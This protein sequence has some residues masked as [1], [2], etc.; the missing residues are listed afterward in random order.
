[1]KVYLF[2]LHSFPSTKAWYCVTTCDMAMFSI[3]RRFTFAFWMT[4]A[5]NC[6]NVLGVERNELRFLNNILKIK[7]V[8]SIDVSVTYTNPLLSKLVHLSTVAVY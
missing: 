8:L 3:T 5:F 1:M 6:Q 2:F 7:I 4:R